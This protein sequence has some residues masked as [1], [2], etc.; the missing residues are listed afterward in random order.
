MYGIVGNPETSQEF[1]SVHL[2]LAFKLK[3]KYIHK[4][5]F[6]GYFD[7]VLSI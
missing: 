1:Q 5:I 2:F 3:R 7:I 6:A 4:A